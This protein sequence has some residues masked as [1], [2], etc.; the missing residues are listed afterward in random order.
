MGCG[1]STK[2]TSPIQLLQ[3]KSDMILGLLYDEAFFCE[4]LSCFSTNFFS[5]SVCAF[6][7]ILWSSFCIIL[8]LWSWLSACHRLYFMWSNLKD[9][10]VFF[11]SYLIT[12]NTEFFHY[13]VNTC[14]VFSWPILTLYP[15]ITDFSSLIKPWLIAMYISSVAGITRKGT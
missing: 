1:R 10:V 13:E 7:L 6:I 4:I 5:K 12:L 8:Q 14:R 9:K 15:N 2:W 3:K 11:N